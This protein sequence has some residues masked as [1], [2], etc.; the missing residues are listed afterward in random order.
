MAAIPALTVIVLVALWGAAVQILH[1]RQYLVPAPSAVWDS[2]TTHA[3]ILRQ[4]VLVT[5]KEVLEG[6]VLSAAL[7]VPIGVALGESRVL[8]RVVY[9]LMVIAQIVPKVALGPLMIVWFG[10]GLTAKI[11]FIVLLSFFP[12]VVNTMVGIASASVDFRRLARSVGLG[13]LATLRKVTLPQALPSV[14]AGLKISI[15][16]AVI[17]AVVGEF[18]TAQA[19][20]GFLILTAQGQVDT[21]L[22]FA[23]IVVLTVMGLAFYAIVATIERL[24]TPWQG[25]ERQ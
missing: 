13:P 21:P 12:I 24:A 22:L 17:G 25:D 14:F 4:S 16:L 11:V 15:T 1:I 7:G 18:I 23:A 8:Q 3:G 2:A 5:G 6:F 20:L 10:L 19:G 9:P